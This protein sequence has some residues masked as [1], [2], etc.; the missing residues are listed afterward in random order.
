MPDFVVKQLIQRSVAYAGTGTFRNQDNLIV[1]VSYRTTGQEDYRLLSINGIL[2]NDP[3]PKESYEEV[4]GTSSTG[5]FVN[6]LATIF[7]P[8]TD[9]HFNAVETDIVRGRKAIVFEYSTTKD[10]AHQVI[11]AA[12][13]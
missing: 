3:K 10:N 11:S 9:T 4:G 7:K 13:C 12:A 6:V 1:A 2:Q 5:E 8:E